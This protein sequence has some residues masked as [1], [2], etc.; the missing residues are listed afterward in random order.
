MP[1]NKYAEGYPGRR[2]YGGCEVV[3]EI[4]QLAI[5]RAGSSAPS[6]RTCS[7]TRAPRR[8][9]PP[10]SR[11]CSPATRFSRCGSITAG[12]SRTAQ[13]QLLGPPLHDRALRRF[14]RDRP[15]RLRRG[16]RA[17]QGAPPGADRLRR[18]RLSADGVT[19]PSSAGSRT[20]RR[21]AH[22]R[23]GAFLGARR[24]RPAPEPRRALRR[25]VLDDPQDARGPAGR[26][27][28][29]PR[30]ARAGGRPGRLPGHAGWPT[31]ARDRSEGDLLQDRRHRSC[32]ARIRSR[33]AQT[34]TRSPTS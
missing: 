7:R 26:L 12:T 29:L 14:A 22:V 16:A 17:R 2:Y 18:L 34:R 9:W 4:E 15:G 20:G 13:G 3:D 31:D 1:T 10:T 28:A 23:H 6:T 19:R 21:P 30:G 32:S 8:T 25:I 33:C 27:R 5:D 24:R 11:C